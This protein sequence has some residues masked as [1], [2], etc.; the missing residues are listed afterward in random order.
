VPIDQ[1]FATK[2]HR[3]VHC[4]CLLKQYHMDAAGTSICIGPPDEVRA[5]PDLTRW[6]PVMPICS[7]RKVD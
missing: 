3:C 4:V 2:I 1:F 5:R 7:C 6:T